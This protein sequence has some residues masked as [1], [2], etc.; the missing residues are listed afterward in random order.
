MGFDGS[1][2]NLKRFIGLE[3]SELDIQTSKFNV[4]FLD[5][6]KELPSYK[7]QKLFKSF[8]HILNRC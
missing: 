2:G 4:E 8:V 1:I 5:F 6:R 7:P 3:S